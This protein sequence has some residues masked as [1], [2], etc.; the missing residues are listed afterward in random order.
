MPGRNL[1]RNRPLLELNAA[2]MTP[3]QL[4]QKQLDA[5]NARDLEGLLR[6]YADDAQ[7]FEHPAKLLAAG[8]SQLRERFMT[9]FQEPNLHAKLCRRIVM[10][11][12]VID[13]EQVTRTFPEGSG[14]IEL[15]MIYEVRNARIAKAWVITGAKS[16]DHKLGLPH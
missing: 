16:L 4:I 6:I 11:D 7:M 15:I 14:N 13:Y 3:E 2:T 10:G 8:S 9:R 5:Y 12:T 1:D